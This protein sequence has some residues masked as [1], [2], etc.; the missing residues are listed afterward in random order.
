MTEV[1]KLVQGQVPDPPKP[2]PL[3]V[4]GLIGEL[5]P[6]GKPFSKA[7]RDRWLEALRVNL[8]LIYGDDRRL[9]DVLR[10]GRRTVP[11]PPRRHPPPVPPPGSR[12]PRCAG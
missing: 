11:F 7:A 12:G 5:P 10:Q 1:A 6:R 9:S 8:D 3:L 2:P 4:Q